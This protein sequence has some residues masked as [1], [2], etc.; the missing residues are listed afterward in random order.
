MGGAE[1]EF[2]SVPRLFTVF[3]SFSTEKLGKYLMIMSFNIFPDL[4]IHSYIPCIFFD[5]NVTSADETVSWV[6]DY[7]SPLQIFLH[8]SSLT[9][10]KY[11]L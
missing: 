9:K 10:S 7:G 4:I 11:V 6:W 2:I 1:F 3:Y 8:V 5:V